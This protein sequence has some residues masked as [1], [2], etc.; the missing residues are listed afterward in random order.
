I[1][2]PSDKILAAKQQ[3]LYAL[4]SSS[5]AEG[6]TSQAMRY[7]DEAATL[8]RHNRATAAEVTLLQAETLM[9]EGNTADAVLKFRKYLDSA[10]KDA[11]NRPAALY[12]LGYALFS[13]KRY[14][15]A[16]DA[17]N[18]ALQSD[19][20]AE[21]RA[22]VL[23]RL[24]DIAYY[25]TD[26][27]SAADF[28][29]RAYSTAPDAGDYAAFNV[30]LMKGYARDYQG[31]LDALQ[32]FRSEFPSSALIPD[33]LLET[34]QAQI[35]LGHNSEAVDTYRRLIAEYPLTA[36]G[37]RGYLQMALTLLDMGR[38]E[39][40]ITAY[41]DVISNYP[42]SEE[43]VQASSLLKNLYAADGRAAEYLDF[44]ASVN[45]APTVSEEEA[46]RL[47]YES[48]V[49]NLDKA[50][51][52]NH[53]E[54]LRLASEMLE[55]Y[56]DSRGAETALALLAQE[57]YDQ[58]RMPEAL[59]R[60]QQLERK[61]SD[62]AIMSK[63]RQGIMRAARDMGDYVL[64]GSS[65]DAILSS[66][67]VSNAAAAEARFT[68]AVALDAEDKTDEAITCWL[69]LAA[70]PSGL[71]GA[72]SAVYAAEALLEQGKTQKARKTAQDLTSSGSSQSYWVARGFIVLADCYAAQGKK[73]E[74]KE[75]LEAL[76]DNYPGSE[77]DITTMIETRLAEL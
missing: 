16:S 44:M 48:A 9:A 38:R 72:K 26:F 4:G 49:A 14:P 5:Y 70:D 32:E 58:G 11:A 54:S 12:G 31:K 67:A 15:E 57:D 39:E 34:T 66:S 17:F 40:A 63:A 27:S 22:D 47:R 23:N 46:H 13:Q 64:A 18:R 25:S 50:I 43:A 2:N 24:G 68:R 69:E 21:A 51:R 75:Y 8:A 37:R 55:R 7:L 3:I 45:N 41:R 33:A 77:T 53:G 29:G 76:R 59:S 1:N 30:A 20:S 56:P 42:T 60:W 73:F 52:D 65:A 62:A 36:Q 61:A 28:Y 10:A 6:K 71:Y 19:L 35:S 74:A